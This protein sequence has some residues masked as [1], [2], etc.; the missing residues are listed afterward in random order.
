[1]VPLVDTHALRLSDFLEKHKIS[2]DEF[3]AVCQRAIKADK[4]AD[5]FLEI[6]LASM[7]YDAFFQ[8][9]KAMRGRARAERKPSLRGQ[10][11]DDRA[12]TKSSAKSARGRDEDD[13]EEKGLAKKR[14]GDDG[15]DGKDAK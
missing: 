6:V 13:D 5:N 9:M 11:D 12:D 14:S 2:E 8:L 4:R 1:M 10:E 3:A 15:D 7:D